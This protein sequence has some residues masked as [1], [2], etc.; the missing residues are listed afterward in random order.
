MKKWPVA[1]VAAALLTSGLTATEAFAA[2]P[3]PANVH[4]SWK[5]E[6]FQKV[7]LTWTDET[8]QANR[9]VLR[10]KGSTKVLEAYRVAA[11]APDV[12][13]VAPQIL[14]Y[15][16]WVSS[17]EGPLE[18]AVTTGTTEDTSPATGSEAFDA[19]TPDRS[20][21]VSAGMSGT[22]TI[23]AKWAPK[24]FVDTTPNDPLDRNIPI[25]YTP[26]YSLTQGGPKTMI[27]S[28]GPATQLTFTG[29]QS[30]YW[31]G[32]IAHNEWGGQFD[33]AW[34]DARQTRIA[35]KIP[36]WAVYG[37]Y[38]VSITGTYTPAEERRQVVL[39]ARNSSTSPWYVVSS[40]SFTGGK[41]GFDL[42]TGGSR[43]YRVAIPN[44]MDYG[45]VASFGAYSGSAA[46]TTQ[47]NAFG[48][49]TWTTQYVGMKN[50][51]TV[52]V[53]PKISTTASLQRWNGKTWTTV[54][55]VKV[56]NG[57]G[58]AQMLSARVGRVAYRYYVPAATYAGLYFAA[59][60]TN[61]FYSVTV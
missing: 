39:Q 52:D 22:S 2:D 31:F 23:T 29:P 6:T 57:K 26:Y 3:A 37:K 16:Q 15:D 25:T 24:L 40:R 59:S 21:L 8:P 5:D 28:R 50:P 51:A 45:Y 1:I 13:E 12:L 19:Y 36:A 58:V 18:F 11:D 4:V 35:V 20:T 32:V 47:L 55:P 46:S 30:T 43:Q 27:G 48:Y 10:H 49:F 60:Y 14:R 56:T 33:G 42:G 53:L 54:G 41:F 17:A 44:T 34:V 9:I 7:Q 38:G 61:T